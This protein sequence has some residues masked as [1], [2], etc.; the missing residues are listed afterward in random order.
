[1]KICFR[2]YEYGDD[3]YIVSIRY[4]NYDG[5]GDRT[6]VIVTNDEE[7]YCNVT[8]K[9]YVLDGYLNIDRI[10]DKLL[11]MNIIYNDFESEESI[12]I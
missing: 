11:Q 2:C 7:K 10:I 12:E 5:Y 8:M 9:K 3:Y 4:T 1:M 6:E